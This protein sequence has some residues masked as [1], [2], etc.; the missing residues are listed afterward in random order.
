MT[1]NAVT[2]RWRS[3]DVAVGRWCA[4]GQPFVAELIAQQGFGGDSDAALERAA[5]LGDG[6]FLTHTAAGCADRTQ[7]FWERVDE[8][9]R[10]SEMSL[11]GTVYQGP[12]ESEAMLDDIAAWAGLGAT[13]LNLRTATYPVQWSEGHHVRKTDVNEHL[14]ALRR[15]REA[16]LGR[17]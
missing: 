13:H 17:S 7:R 1:E 3:G 9:G 2:A 5:R 16:W 15:V 6:G 12:R 4:T 14:G 8:L 11:I 10:R